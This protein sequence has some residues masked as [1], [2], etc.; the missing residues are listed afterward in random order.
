MPLRN[1]LLRNSLLAV[2]VAV[3][4]LGLLV[5]SNGPKGL[6]YHQVFAASTNGLLV[7]QVY[8]WMQFAQY[9][10]FQL[11]FLIFSSALYIWAYQALLPFVWFWLFLLLQLVLASQYER[12]AKW[13]QIPLLKN[14]LIP[15]MWFIQLNFI[16]AMLGSWNLF[17]A[18]FLV[19]YL[20]L[21]LQADLEDID[22]D[23]GKITTLVGLLG[24]KQAGF[25]IVFLFSFASFLLGLPWVWIMLALLVMRREL[26]LPK[27]SYD[28]L[29][30]VL[31]IYF[32]LR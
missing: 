17:N 25:L 31:G 18:A 23:S 7:G 4:C 10:R 1:S 19:F 32:L 5:Y 6:T 22:E 29:L 27:R 24:A 15:C 8:F 30:L 28:A 16:P 2:F 3:Y 21:S 26:H 20:A 11:I 13:R 12:G 14:V 9:K